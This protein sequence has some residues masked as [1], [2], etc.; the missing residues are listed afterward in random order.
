MAKFEKLEFSINQNIVYP[1]HGVGVIV[2]IQAQEISGMSLEL[3]VIRFER[4]RMT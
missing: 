4:E 1:K 3:Y 2:D